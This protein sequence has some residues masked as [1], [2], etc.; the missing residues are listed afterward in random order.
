MNVHQIIPFDLQKRLGVAYNSDMKRIPEGDAALLMDWDVQLLTHDA[1]NIIHEYA[2]RNPNAVLTCYTNRVSPLAK[3][4][5]LNGLSEETDIRKHI[6]IAE[7]QKKYL[8]EV[9]PINQWIA[10]M[11]M[12]V[13]KTL[14]VKHPFPEGFKCLGV[15]TWWSKRLLR[16]GVKI[17]RMNGIYCFHQ[18]RLIHGIY[19][20]K[21]LL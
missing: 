11:L 3:P 6:A 20:K 21:H 14:W 16:S 8:Y 4:Q 5:L 19:H 9:T 17:L 18:Y 12:V 13:P 10:G 7:E 15:D 2:N 1:R